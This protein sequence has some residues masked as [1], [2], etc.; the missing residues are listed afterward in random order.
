M[1]NLTIY[2]QPEEKAALDRLARLMERDARA[3]AKIIILDALYDY[4]FLKPR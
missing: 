4:A 3:Q 1:P 2:L